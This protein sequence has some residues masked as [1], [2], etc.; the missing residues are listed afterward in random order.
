MPLLLSVVIVRRRHYRVACWGYKGKQR[1]NPNQIA[2]P[3]RSGPDDVC[4][5]ALPA[6]GTCKLSTTPRFQRRARAY[7]AAGRVSTL[8][9]EKSGTLSTR[10][11]RILGIVSG[12]SSG[13]RGSAA[14]IS[15]LLSGCSTVLSQGDY[16]ALNATART[17]RCSVKS[18]PPY[19]CADMLDIISKFASVRN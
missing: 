9:L 15:S 19:S 11:H 10:T 5:C 17:G 1:W 3:F 6:R 16:V 13:R 2:A 8:G 7:I 18:F 4:H 12:T 14:S